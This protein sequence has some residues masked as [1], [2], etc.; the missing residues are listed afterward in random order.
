MATSSQQKQGLF[1]AIWATAGNRSRVRAIRI[2]PQ[3]ASN[4][5]TD[6]KFKVFKV[7][8]DLNNLI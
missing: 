4:F 3:A 2:L 8:K 6:F 1:K 5:Q 7:L